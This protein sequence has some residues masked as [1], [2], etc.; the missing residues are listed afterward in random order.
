MVK[1]I[2][3]IKVDWK[4]LLFP[5][6]FDGPDF[7]LFSPATSQVCTLACTLGDCREGQ[8]PLNLLWGL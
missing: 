5:I 7:L 1:K 4:M 3:T 6:N 8:I 2:R